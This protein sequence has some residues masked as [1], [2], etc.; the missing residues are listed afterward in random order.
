MQTN[1]V[2]HIGHSCGKRGPQ[3][4]NELELVQEERGLS[5]TITADLKSSR[6]C[7]KSAAT[8]RRVTG[9][10]RINFRHLD[11]DDIRLT[12]VTPATP[13]ALHP[14]SLVSTFRQKD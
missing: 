9:M 14:S 12:Y 4:R 8:A 11:I 3:G 7:I 10:V 2:M 13:R 6:Q 1:I 5:V